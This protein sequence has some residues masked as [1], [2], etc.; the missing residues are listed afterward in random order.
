VSLR[1]SS[2]D[3]VDKGVLGGCRKKVLLFIFM[4]LDFVKGDMGEGVKA[5]DGSRGDRGTG[6]NVSRAVRDVGEGVILQVVKDR[7]GELRGWGAWDKRSRCWGSVS[8]KIGTW[9]IPSIV[10]RLEDFK[11]GSGSV[12]NVLLV[13]V[14][15]GQPGGD[16]DVGEGGGGDNS[17]LRGSEGHFTYTVSSTLETVLMSRPT[18]I[19]GSS[20]AT[21]MYLRWR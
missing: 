15:K 11:D 16:R 14:I 18:T 21:M 12:S 2:K 5:V 7:P 9:E 3:L 19:Y 10:V 13:Y 6:D 1:I 8:V 17:G 4:V 20:D